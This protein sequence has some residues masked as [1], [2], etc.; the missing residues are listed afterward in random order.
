MLSKKHS[1]PGFL[2]HHSL[3]ANPLE[4]ARQKRLAQGLPLIDLTDS[5][6]TH[7]GFIFP[8]EILSAAAARYIAD[9]RY[10]PDP[11][12]SL[13]ARRAICA[14]YAARTPALKLSPD[15]IFIT[16]STSESYR[17]LFSLLCDPGDNVLVSQVT[18]PLFDLLAEDRT[19]ALKTYTLEESSGWRINESTLRKAADPRTRAVLF[20]SP[21]NPTGMICTQAL[22]AVNTLQKP[23]ISDE[24]FAEFVHAGA[25]APPLGTL[26]PELPVFHLNGISKMFA[27]PDLKL[28][29]MALSDQAM[30]L[31]GERLEH[32]N[33]A[34]LSCSPLIQAMLPDI[35]KLGTDFRSA[36]VK[37]ITSRVT[38]AL[39]QLRASPHLRVTR[40]QGGAFILARVLPDFDEDELVLGLIEA[41]VLV[42]PGYFYGCEDGTHIMISCLPD[43]ARLSEGIRIILEFLEKRQPRQRA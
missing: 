2:A 36:M 17:L 38:A 28:G 22:E 18:Y 27:L 3:T 24:V 35:F 43:G 19:L 13:E 6:P 33:D 29:W 26:Y 7:F 39:A 8:P 21:H 40:P 10:N 14:Y 31:Y 4:D 32:L 15:Q 25:S 34:F 5:N 41:G 30:A 23:I 1:M 37:T 20:V 12:G 9:R 11:R 42:H 16:A